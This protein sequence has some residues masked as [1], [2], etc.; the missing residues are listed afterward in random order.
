LTNQIA[1]WI[2]F[3]LFVFAVLALD[4]GLLR[5][6]ARQ[7]RPREGLIWTAVWVALAAAF[8]AGIW[9]ARGRGRA[10]EYATAYLV[11]YS[12]SVDN[13]FVFVLV[14]TH[15]RVPP[16][17]RH[18][19]LFWGI[20]GAF[21][22]RAT[23]IILGAALVSRFHWLLYGF[24]AFLLYSAAKM[25]LSRED[26]EINPERSAVLRWARRLLPVSRGETGQR[27]FVRE[28]GG[29]K[30]TPLF[31][32]LLV[33]EATDLLFAFDSIPAVLGISRDSFIV[34]TSN[35]F[36]I[37]GLRSLFFVLAGLIDRFHYLKLGV[38]AV[39]AFVGGKM[40]VE[41]WWQVPLLA[42]LAVVG[43]LLAAAVLASVWRAAKS[44][45]TALS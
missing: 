29:L 30:V 32:I 43:A 22:M 15:F 8:C 11:E 1:L 18:R 45:P 40:L 20:L 23:L 14:F 28:D 12:L 44:N 16:R 36:A 13:L 5:R 19:L 17:Y 21:A 33:I 25:M 24:G 4:L 42:S 7:I 3:H 37:L 26:E 2:A 9:L 39:L 38:S 34:Y 27:F 6:R 10:L 31:L 35:V 41:P